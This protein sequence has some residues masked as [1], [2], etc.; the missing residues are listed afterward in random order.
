[1]NAVLLFELSRASKLELQDT[2]R[3]PSIPRVED[4]HCIPDQIVKS[5]PGKAVVLLIILQ[6]MYENTSPQGQASP[7]CLCH[8]RSIVVSQEKS[9]RVESGEKL[10][11][12]KIL[13]SRISKDA[14]KVKCILI[15]RSEDSRI[16]E[17]DPAHAEKQRMSNVENW[18]EEEL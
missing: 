5:L 8:Q 1:M 3:Y 2:R 16:L 14:W 9:S 17:N 15:I 10:P 12:L 13:S 18:I 4:C 7:I 6:L 11:I